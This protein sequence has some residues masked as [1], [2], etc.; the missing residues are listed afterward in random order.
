MAHPEHVFLVG[1]EV[2]RVRF[3]DKSGCTVRIA[4]FDVSDPYIR[5]VLLA[6]GT[7]EVASVQ[8]TPPG[9]T[10]SVKVSD[11]EGRRGTI[12]VSTFN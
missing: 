10:V 7:L 2:E 1:E 5:V 3:T 4:S 6:E 8:G 12:L 11:T 9:T